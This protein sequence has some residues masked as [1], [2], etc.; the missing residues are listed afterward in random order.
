MHMTLGLHKALQQR[1]NEEGIRFMGRS[2]TYAEFGDRVARLAG[3]LRKL[4]VATGDRVAM[5]S[6]NS[7]R[8]LEYDMAVPWAGGVLNPV[9]IRWSP[10]EILYSL[11]DSGTSVLIVDD[12]FKAAAAAMAGQAKTVRHVIYAGDGETPA[13][14]LNYEDLIAQSEP[15]EDA[16]RHGDD[17]AGIFYTGGTTGFPKGVM[18]SHANLASAAMSSLLVGNLGADARFLHC[19]PMFHLADFGPVVGLF[20][21][22]GAHVVIPMFDPRLTLETIDRERINQTLMAPTVLQMTLDWIDANPEAAAKI[23]LSSLQKLFYGASTIS[24]TLLER[25]RKAFAN[26]GFC[27]GYGMTELSPTAAILLPEDHHGKRPRAAGKA[28]AN[29]ELKIVDGEGDEVPR[30]TVGEIIVRGA[31]VMLGY[32]NKPQETAKAVRNGWMHTGDGG[33]MDDDGFVYIADRIKDM[34]ITGG[35]NVYSGE[36]ENALASHPAVKQCAVIGVP[37]EKWGETVHAV[38]VP[39]ADQMVDLA[40]VQAHCRDLIAGYKLPRS[41]EIRDA[42]PMSSVGKVLKNELRRTSKAATA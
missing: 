31:N 10:A 37:H 12:T 3:A 33:Y 7:A 29:V 16:Y 38:V 2:M 34:I 40:S 9:N 17:L 26:V 42:L 32:W 27:Q 39:K 20:V 22:G 25:A 28:V 35:E 19:M 11:D 14:M 41:L 13:G 5:Y 30:G 36:V 8:Y 15:V 23:D 1:P 18:L 4:G 6:L 21:S 24:Q